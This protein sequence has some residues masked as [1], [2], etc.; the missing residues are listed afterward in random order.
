MRALQCKVLYGNLRPCIANT[1]YLTHYCVVRSDLPFGAQAAQLIHAAGQSVTEP[2][3]EGTYAIALHVKDET[4]LYRLT[5]RLELAGIQHT[6]I[7]ESDAPYTGQLMAIGIPPQDR[8][9]LKPLLSSYPLLRINA[10]VAQSD[11]ASGVMTQKAGGLNPS[12]RATSSRSTL[13]RI[14]RWLGGKNSRAAPSKA[15]LSE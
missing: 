15:P 1:Q 12:G 4:E 8:A 10:P 13:Q 9:K 2:A 11:R 7:R 6:L 5:A 14:R 3:P